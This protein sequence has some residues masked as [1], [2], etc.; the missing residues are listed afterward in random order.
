[1]AAPADVSAV[2]Q[3]IAA[4]AAGLD[5]WTESIFHPALFPGRDPATVAHQAFAV[6]CPSSER[7][8]GRERPGAGFAYVRTRVALRFT[9]RLTPKDHVDAFDAALV[10]EDAMLT[11]L[12]TGNW[13]TNFHLFWDG[14]AR[15]LPPG[16]PGWQ[17]AEL[18]L[19]A[20]HY[21]SL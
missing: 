4:R 16:L 2:R 6:W 12:M 18:Q 19:A 7:I 9:Y 20:L 14:S 8:D 13:S 15:S 17:L 21:V 11:R 5:G 10:A 1:M 3:A